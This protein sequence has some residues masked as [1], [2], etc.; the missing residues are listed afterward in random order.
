[1][2]LTGFEE[3]NQIDV[4]IADASTS[5]KD[6]NSPFQQ[7]VQ[8]TISGHT[9]VKVK[10]DG[11]VDKDARSVPVF[12]T[13]VGNLFLSTIIRSQVK[14]DGSVI[15]PNGTFNEFVK[16]QIAE[17]STNKEIMSAVVQGCQGKRI[18]VTRVP[19]AGLTRDNRPIAKFLVEL[20]FAE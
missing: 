12:K 18:R 2:A 8:F 5:I 20:N 3:V 14:S 7:N 13:S 4:E 9:Y 6:S 19:Y 17:K 11:I 16:R 1:M 10:N 15:T